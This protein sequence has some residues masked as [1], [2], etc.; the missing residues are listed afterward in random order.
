MVAFSIHC[1]FF[2]VLTIPLKTCNGFFS[3]TRQK[4]TCPK[5][6][7]CLRG[8][9][10]GLAICPGLLFCP[11]NCFISFKFE[12][13]C[14]RWKMVN[15]QLKRNLSILSSNKKAVEIPENEACIVSDRTNHVAVVYDGKFYIDKVL[16]MLKYHLIN[17]Q[18]L[19]Q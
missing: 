5:S 14:D 12:T 7:A 2:I 4:C 15:L 13:A 3:F 11:Q 19:Y 9:G 6:Q 17:M 18:E 16:L 10:I 8:F 1:N